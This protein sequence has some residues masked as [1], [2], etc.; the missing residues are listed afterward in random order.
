[1]AHQAAEVAELVAFSAE[2]DVVARELF[3]RGPEWHRLAGRLA[4]VAEDEL[5]RV[6]SIGTYLRSVRMVYERGCV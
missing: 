1:V 5:R 2:A 3:R 4:L 6:S